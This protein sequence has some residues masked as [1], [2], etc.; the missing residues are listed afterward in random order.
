MVFLNVA[1]FDIDKG[2]VVPLP[3]TVQICSFLFFFV[4]CQ[5][6]TLV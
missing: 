5:T 2:Y 1:H 4:K 6:V 3:F